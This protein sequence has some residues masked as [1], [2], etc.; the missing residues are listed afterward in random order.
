MPDGDVFDR[1]I[2]RGWQTASR[3]VL[4]GGEGQDALPSVLRALGKEVR[5]NGCPGLDQIVSVLTSAIRSS[6][7]KAMRQPALVKLEHLRVQHGDRITQ[8]AIDSARRL[9]AG[10]FEPGLSTRQMMDDGELRIDLCTTMLADLADAFMCPAALLPRLVEE[11]NVSFQAFH[12]R[13]QRNK[14]SIVGAPESRRLAL[15]LLADPSGALVKVPQIR[16]ERLSQA[17]ILAT[18]LTH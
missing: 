4:G 16:R 10:G 11:G 9:L 5:A 6:Q 15:Q 12:S 7:P 14:E 2:R 1:S 18:A 17:E 8:L 13:R 3:R